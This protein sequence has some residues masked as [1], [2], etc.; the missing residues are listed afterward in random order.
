MKKSRFMVVMGILAVLGVAGSGNAGTFELSDITQFTVTGTTPAE[1]FIGRGTGAVNFLNRTGD[2][3]AWAHNFTFSPLPD[4]ILGATL[5]LSLRDDETNTL[6][7]MTWEFGWGI[8]EDGSWDLGA[9]SSATYTYGVNVDYLAD[10]RFAVMIG[11]LA[12]DFYIDQSVL[13][14]TYET[15]DPIVSTAVPD[16]GSTLLLFGMALGVLGLAGWCRGK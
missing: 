9:I 15:A 3:V 7:P 12:G 10:G 13:N 1:D 6:N 14:I 2:Y 16:P 8:A 5:T 4:Q 11:S